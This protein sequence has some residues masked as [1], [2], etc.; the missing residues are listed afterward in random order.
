[1]ALKLITAPTVEPFAIAELKLQSDVIRT[2]QDTLI[3]AY[4]VA[5]REKIE[6]F[7]WRK[8]I[9]QTWELHLE[10]FPC[11]QGAIELP[12]PPLQSVT[13]VKYL[14]WSGGTLLTLDPSEYV[15]DAVSEPARVVPAYQRIWPVVRC[16]PSAVIVRFVCGYG[17]AATNVPESI[18]LGIKMLFDHLYEN[19]GPILE[20][21]RAAAIEIPFTFLDFLDPYR[22]KSF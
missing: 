15:V 1:M 11:R 19:R 14:D 4:G 6:N 5:A 16:Q 13:S 8:L 2:D 22:I 17:A 18:R 21:G 3:T 20:G 7:L 10:D 9:T 12:F